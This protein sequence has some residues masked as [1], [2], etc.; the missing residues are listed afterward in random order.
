VTGQPPGVIVIGMHRSSTSLVTAA[1]AE[2]GFWM[3]DDQL[4]ARPDNP[5]GYYEDREMHELHRRLL[6][7]YGTAWDTSPQ[8]R[9]LRGRDLTVPPELEDTVQRLVADYRAHAPWVWKNPRATLF[10]DEWGRR[11]PEATFVLCLR[12]PGEVVD[13]MLRRQDRMRISTR[14]SFYRTRRLLRGLS[15]WRSYNLAAWQFAKRQPERVV[16]VR[17]PQDLPLVSAY[18][19]DVFEASLLRKG[20]AQVR[21]PALLALRTR[22]LHRRLA[23]RADPQR[24]EALLRAPM[25]DPR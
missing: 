24:L 19:G 10:C 14:R 13:S 15:I 2:S 18:A 1:F 11:F 17:I 20:R 6:E 8:L 21:L 12:A 3:P 9:R 25:P 5:K 7:H 4:Q 23:R 16:V 22:W